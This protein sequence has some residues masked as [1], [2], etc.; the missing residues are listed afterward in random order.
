MKKKILLIPLV[1]III[2]ILGIVLF[3]NLGLKAVSSD[4]TE[5]DFIVEEGS[6]YYSVIKKLKEENLIKNEL[7]FKIY[8]KLNN[9]NNIQAGTYK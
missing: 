1:L 5:V 4:N 6:T 8:I 7:C 2:I 3:Y 9:K